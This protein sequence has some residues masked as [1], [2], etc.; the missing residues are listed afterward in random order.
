[1]PT[2]EYAVILS[3]CKDRTEA[4]S[5]AARLV[6]D[7]AAACV[8]IVDTITSIYRWKGKV[9]KTTEA[10]LIIKTRSALADRVERT[11]RNLSSYECPEVI[12]LPIVK[13]SENYLRWIAGETSEGQD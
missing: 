11:I 4:E 8:S 7:G 5:I 2:P 3:T 12:V 1:M 6:N 13:G 9:E 10:L